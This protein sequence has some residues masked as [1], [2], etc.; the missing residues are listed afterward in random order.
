MTTTATVRQTRGQCA[1]RVHVSTARAAR[2][3]S[4][5]CAPCPPAPSAP[6]E[7]PYTIHSEA[8]V[9]ASFASLHARPARA[10]G[11][12]RDA[13]ETNAITHT[14]LLTSLRVV[15]SSVAHLAQL[16]HVATWDPAQSWHS[17]TPQPSPG[18]KSGNSSSDEHTEQLLRTPPGDDSLPRDTLP[19]DNS[20]SSRA[21]AGC[22]RRTADLGGSFEPQPTRSSRCMVTW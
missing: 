6:C 22:C 20:A 10:H 18:Q 8:V 14:R 2:T 21:H 1:D 16:P 5:R 15:H 4:P 12:R 7:E 9:S 19:R 3:Q 13:N 17:G 11:A